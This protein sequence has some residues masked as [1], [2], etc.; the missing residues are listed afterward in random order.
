MPT[1]SETQG[2]E[3][4]AGRPAVAYL[5]VG[6]LLF[7]GLSGVAG[8]LGLILDPTGSGI[9]LDPALIEGSLFRDYLVPGLVLFGLLGIGPLVVALAVGRRAPWSWAGSWL[10]G[11]A[12]LVWLSV[13]V[14]VVGA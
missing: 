11:L 5:L 12:L 13:E 1:T 9:G 14:L 8:G 7:Q 3:R 10:A 4:A 6:L 2:M